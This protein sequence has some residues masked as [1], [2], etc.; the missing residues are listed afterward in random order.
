MCG[1]QFL[2]RVLDGRFA[3]E[4]P[5]YRKSKLLRKLRFNTSGIG[6]SVSERAR[7]HE[8]LQTRGAGSPINGGNLQSVRQLVNDQALRA[9]VVQR[10]HLVPDVSKQLATVDPELT[11]SIQV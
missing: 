7:K 11:A 6:Q 1:R 4:L 3:Y 8:G 10:A 2:E 5:E 9:E